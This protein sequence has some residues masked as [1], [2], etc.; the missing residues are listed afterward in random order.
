MTREVR[1]DELSARVLDLIRENDARD[2]AERKR[3]E[4]AF[5]RKNADERTDVE[6]AGS[7]RRHANRLDVRA[8]QLDERADEIAENWDNYLSQPDRRPGQPS[9]GTER[10]V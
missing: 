10:S 3:A 6:T 8:G 1:A 4:A 7:D 5:W 2:D 9:S